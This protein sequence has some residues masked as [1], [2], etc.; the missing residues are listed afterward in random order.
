MPLLR[1]SGCNCQQENTFKFPKNSWRD[2]LIDMCNGRVAIVQP[3]V[4]IIIALRVNDDREDD[5]EGKELEF[6]KS[7][8]GE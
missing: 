8:H 4:C 1:F 7:E 3:N 6:Q 2:L 5:P